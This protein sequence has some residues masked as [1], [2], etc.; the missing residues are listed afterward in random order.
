MGQCG[1][2]ALGVALLRGAP[3]N[4]HV[5]VAAA[6]V[7]RLPHAQQVLLP[8]ASHFAHY[9]QAAEFNKLVAAFVK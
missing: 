6:G 2:A 1:P 5:T 4:E 3:L 7:A 9:E 8:E